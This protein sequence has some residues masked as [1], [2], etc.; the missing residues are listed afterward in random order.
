MNAKD[1]ERDENVD[2]DDSRPTTPTP[3]R[4]NDALGEE[5]DEEEEESEGEEIDDDFLARELAEELG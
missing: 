5:E 3:Q 1:F 2:S 4:G